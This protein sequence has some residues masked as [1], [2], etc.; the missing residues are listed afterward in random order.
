MKRKTLQECL[1]ISFKHNNPIKHPEF[2]NYKHFSFILQGNKIVDWGTNRRGSP[3]TFLGYEPYQKIH[4]EV[5]AYFKARGIMDRSRSFDV[6]NIRLTK[7]GV[8]KVSNPCKCCT[9]F[10]KN[11]GCRRIYSTTNDGNFVCLD[12]SV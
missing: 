7:R 10:L 9:G 4:S 1:N 11:L 3:Y 6:V 5:D 8:V 12:F 2:D